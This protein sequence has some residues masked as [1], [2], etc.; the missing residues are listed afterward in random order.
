MQIA[1]AAYR[2]NTA[3]TN[4]IWEGGNFTV[5]LHTSPT[6]VDKLAD[7]IFKTLMSPF[8]SLNI[9]NPPLTDKEDIK[10]LYGPRQ[11]NTSQTVTGAPYSSKNINP[12]GQTNKTASGA[13]DGTLDF[14]RPAPPLLSQLSD[15]QIEK[16]MFNDLNYLFAKLNNVYS[17]DEAGVYQARVSSQ[18]NLFNATEQSSAALAPK[19][20]A[21]NCRNGIC[22][23]G[24]E[25]LTINDKTSDDVKIPVSPSRVTLKFYAYADMNQM[26]I[27]DVKIDWG[28][29]SSPIQ[30]SGYF[31]NHRGKTTGTKCDFQSV[32][33]EFNAKKYCYI[34]TASYNTV[35]HKE[36][37]GTEK[38]TN[39]EC[40]SV[41][42]CKNID[43]CLPENIAPN[44]GQIVDKTCDNA[45]FRADYSYQCVKDSANFVPAS[46]CP[47]DLAFKEGCCKYTPKVQVKD[48]WGWC[49]GVCGDANSPG[50]TG[51]YDRRQITGN[52]YDDE[53]FPL[54]SGAWT[55]FGGSSPKSIIVAPK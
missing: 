26:P 39:K 51:C 47:S 45:Y 3:K 19:I 16:G 17:L 41:N 34:K 7:Y 9:T 11:Q 14:S 27:R 40:Q 31:R 50:K 24:T 20:L 30:L 33:G 46:Q 15:S 12:G 49:N 8:G 52:T 25:G 44:F 21:V 29:G 5:N 42:D 32:G 4:R 22:F 6:G 10:L 13:V 54:D 38:P 35:T 43:Q 37:Y 1:D 53:C 18:N 28:D 48:N 36:V 23:E 55:P 2:A